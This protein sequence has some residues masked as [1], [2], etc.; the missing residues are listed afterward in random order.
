MFKNN[1]YCLIAGLPDIVADDNKIPFLLSDFIEEL[2]LHLAS[3]DYKF[4]KLF[5]LHEDNRTL[6]SLL[7]KKE[8]KEIGIANY[9]VSFI[10]EQLR[11]PKTLP[12]YMIEFINNHNQEKK[13]YGVTDENELTWFFYDYLFKTKS[14]FV[15]DWFEFDMNLKNLITA[16]NC[17]KF[18]KEVAKE[19]IGDNEFAKALRSSKLK[20]FGLSGDYQIV[21]KVISIN[22]STNLVDKEKQLDLLRWEYLEEKITFEYFTIDRVLSYL[23]R[24]Q[25]ID[26]WS[27][28]DTDSGKAVFNSLIKRLKESFEFSEEFKV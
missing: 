2:Q 16:L 9:P 23:I 14:D 5:F 11:D 8:P 26:R 4:V 18:D 27:K 12:S 3:K 20:D 24:L 7:D 21:D 22:N 25:I 13:K 6:L 28:L 17:R 19:I 10:E 15:R 1:Y